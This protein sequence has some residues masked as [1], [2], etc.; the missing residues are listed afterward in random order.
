MV[1]VLRAELCGGAAADGEVGTQEREEAKVGGRGVKN[2]GAFLVGGGNVARAQS[3]VSAYV[4][5]EF[6]SAVIFPEVAKDA[7]EGAGVVGAR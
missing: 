2:G 7:G 3:W 5:V 4:A 1:V 6:R